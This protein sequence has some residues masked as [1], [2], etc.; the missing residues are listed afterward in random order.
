MTPRI[1]TA[2]III[3]APNVLITRR[4]PT[5]KLAGYW[6]FPGGK[7]E[8]GETLQKCLERELFEEL[9]IQTAVSAVLA[10][11]IYHYDGGSIRL[12]GLETKILEGDIQLT[13]HD[14]AEWV[15]LEKLLELKLA[16]ADIPIAEII[17]QRIQSV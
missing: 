2:A 4:A 15:H 17:I 1:V 14:A 8:Y 10:E 7:L 3:E 13:V 5:E 16:P 6:E 9:G 11:S 12:I